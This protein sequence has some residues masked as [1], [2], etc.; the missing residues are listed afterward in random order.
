MY[1]GR[2][3]PEMIPGHGIGEAAYAAFRW[4]G[5]LWRAVARLAAPSQGGCREG[6]GAHV[7]ER[8]FIGIITAHHDTI[9]RICWSFAG[10]HA[11]YE[12]MRQDALVNIWRGLDRWRDESSLR[13]WI[14]RVTLNTCVSTWRKTSRRPSASC[15]S[16]A[17]NLSDGSHHRYEDIQWL[18]TLLAALSPADRAIIVMWL[19]RLSYDE[20]GEVMG[21]NRNTVATRVS[22]ARRR[23]QEM[24]RDRRV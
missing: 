6:V 23:M 20:I 9:R 17:D 19:D 16:Y 11:D 22:R 7:S 13:T 12:D 24:A 4:C 15:I 14:Y 21:M 8:E 5:R 18:H 10:T 1:I 3:V 2:I